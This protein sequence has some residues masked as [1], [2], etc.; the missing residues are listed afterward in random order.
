MD[1]QRH[2]AEFF[3]ALAASQQS[4]NAFALREGAGMLMKNL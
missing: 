2:G 4:R 3:A 1:H